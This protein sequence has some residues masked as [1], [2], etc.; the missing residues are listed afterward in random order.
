MNFVGA[1]Q[2]RAVL[3]FTKLTAGDASYESL[4]PTDVVVD[5]VGTFS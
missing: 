4:V 5:V 2:T 3:A 1:N